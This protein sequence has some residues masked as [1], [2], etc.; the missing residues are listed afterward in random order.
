MSDLDEAG[1]VPRIPAHCQLNQTLHD[2][3]ANCKCQH[4]LWYEYDKN[5]NRTKLTHP[6]GQFVRYDYDEL[7][8]LTGVRERDTTLGTQNY[9]A[10]GLPRRMDWHTG[11][12]SRN[13][14]TYTHDA[15]GRVSALHLNLHNSG[16]DVSWIFTRNPA[17]QILSETQTNDSYSWDGHP[18][19]GIDRNYTT[20]GLNQYESAG[21][22][23]FCYDANGNLT[24]DGASVYLYDVENRLV[25]RRQ[26]TNTNCS[27]LSYA[28][29]LEADLR[30]DPLGRLRWV[31]DDDGNITKFLYDGNALV[32]EYDSAGAVLRRYV[33]GN[34]VEAD[35]PLIWYEGSQ[36]VGSQRRYVHADPRGSIVAV[37]GSNGRSLYTNSYDE[38]GIPDTATGDDI[39]TKG[40]FR[41]TGQAW[42]PEIG[43]YYYKARIY[44][45]TLG[46]FLQTDP[47]GYEGG[48]NIYAYA[49]NDPIN[50]ND[51]SGLC[52]VC[53]GVV[54]EGIAQA[55][56][57]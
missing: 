25:E 48:I 40:R 53:W 9:T 34:D 27:N 5:G 6:D 38:F 31:A 46:R 16:R 41:Y 3:F 52:P 54:I 50:L 28:G 30:Y 29:S 2:D 1:Q 11:A 26:Q 12:A 35:D 17:S 14:R 45:P 13:W 37:T 24:A 57:S 47:I 15:A 44:S 19:Q 55:L 49:T 23:A 56:N 43:M 8:R 18:N 33:H 39:P 20:N 10:R 32:L 51:P 22:A 4:Y 21:S 7:N 42:I 36:M